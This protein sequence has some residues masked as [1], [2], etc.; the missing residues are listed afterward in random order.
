MFQKRPPLVSRDLDLKG[1]SFFRFFSAAFG[2]QIQR[3]DSLEIGRFAASP[4]PKISDP[5]NEGGVFFQRGGLFS[6]ISPDRFRRPWW[7]SL[8]TKPM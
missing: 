7:R 5:Q 8:D 6:N 1:G 3:G 4:K 2:G